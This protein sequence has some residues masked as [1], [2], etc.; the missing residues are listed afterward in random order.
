MSSYENGKIYKI[1][2]HTTGLQ[3]IGSTKLKLSERLKGH[4]YAHKY[5]K[6][7]K[8]C[9][10]TSCHVI[11]NNNYS[12]SLIEN[13]PC[14]SRNELLLRESHFIETMKPNVNKQIPIRIRNEIVPSIKTEKPVREYRHHFKPS[15]PLKQCY[16]YGGKIITPKKITCLCGNTLF[17]HNLENHLISEEHY[18]ELKMLTD[19]LL[20]FK[21]NAW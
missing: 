13:Y 18:N 20:S 5:W 11:D 10:T 12:I 8:G 1:V 14:S 21:Y 9:D 6:E 7:G 19:I 2:C 15:S 16:G 4:V 17:E 3:Y